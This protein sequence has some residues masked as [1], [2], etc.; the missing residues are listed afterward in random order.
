MAG[1]DDREKR[2]FAEQWR[3]N[4]TTTGAISASS[5]ALARAIT[6]QVIPGD[7]PCRI[8][9]AGPGT[10]VFT[11][12]IARRMGPFDR[13]DIYEINPAFADFLDARLQGDPAFEA[14]RGRI[15]LHRE[16]I[17]LIPADA[18]YDRI[19][20]S[21]P[22]NNFQ[23]LQVR[24]IFD[25]YFS[26]LTPGGIL[27]Y[28]EYA[29]VRTLKGWVSSSDERRRLRAVEEVTSDFLR[30]FQ[31]RSDPVVLNLPP[32][33]ARHLVKPADLKVP[34]GHVRAPL[35]PAAVVR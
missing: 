34:A 15:I 1:R 29:F 35:Q 6:S 28:F 32:A 8:L 31:V 14:A 25:T 24:K 7:S 21:L 16:D 3:R 23:P 11:V 18:V 9:E 26:R 4:F 19:I 13:L 20:S 10:G 30:R 17:P 27:S 2:I 33:V 22:L 5:R 12:E